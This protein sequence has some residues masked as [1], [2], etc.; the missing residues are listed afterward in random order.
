MSDKLVQDFKSD[1]EAFK[2][3]QDQILADKADGKSVGELQEKLNKINAAIEAKQ[4]EVTGKLAAMET[5]MRRSPMDNGSKQT[6]VNA[7]E[8]KAAFMGFM[9]KGVETGLE[10]IQKKALAVNDDTAGG[11]MVHADLTGRIIKHVFETSPIRAYANVQTIST[12]ALEGMMDINQATSGGWVS[13]A[14]TRSSTATPAIGQWRITAEEQS[15]MPAATQKLLDDAAWD[16]EGWLADKIADKFSRDENAA[17]VTGSGVGKPH[18]FVSSDRTIV[19]DSGVTDDTFQSA[20]KMGY[21][22]TGTSAAF[23][24]ASGNGDCLVNTV[25]ALK[26]EYRARPG[27]AWGM[28][29]T[30]FAAVRTLKDQYGR[31]L[32][33]PSFQAGMPSML[34]GFPVAEFNDMAVMAANSYSIAFANWREAYQIVDRQGIRVMRDPYTSKPYVLF[35]STKRTG[36]DVLNF[37]A[38]KFVKFAA[39]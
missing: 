5:A 1:W 31:Y 24:T 9:R 25:Q 17:F 38:I 6:D 34:L 35:Y 8:H 19:A 4:A 27:V 15:A 33:E 11:Y 29:R 21:V 39:S 2:K 14:G 26:A 3:T 18:G 16:A 23:G 22:P 32:W 7:A 12:D 13:E 30:T 10:A 28:N 20:K 36:G 37:E